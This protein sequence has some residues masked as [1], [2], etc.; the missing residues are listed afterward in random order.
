MRGERLHT[1]L[2]VSDV[3]GMQQNMVFSDEYLFSVLLLL[4][5]QLWQLTTQYLYY[6]INITF[7]NE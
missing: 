7:P 6:P 5:F 1:E 3:S 4:V 2:A